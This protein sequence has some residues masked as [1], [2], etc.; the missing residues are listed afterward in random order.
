MALLGHVC[1]VLALIVCAYGIVVSIHGA[2]SGRAEFSLAGRRSV[3]ALAGLLTVGMIVL[4]IAFVGNDF[5]FNAVADTSSRTTPLLYRLAA[6]WSSQE[7]SLLL[8][9]WLLSMWS[10]LVLFLTRGRLR[11]VASYATA[12]LLGF[13]GFFVGLMVFYANPFTTTNPVPAEGV[14]LDPLLRFPTMMI[15]PPMLYSGYTLCTI[16]LAFA[17][18]A[19]IARRVDGEWIA[20][21]RRFALAAWLFLG[22]GILLGASWSF[23]EL[24]WGGYWGWDAVENASLLPW[25]TGTAFLHSLM[26][27]ERRG[28]LKVWNVSLPLATGILAIMGTFMVR[29]GILDSI[30][31][32]GGA[33]L[34]VPFL[35]LIAALLAGSIYLVVSRRSSL[36]STHHLDSLLSR[37]AIFLFNNLVLVG[38]AFVIFW[39]T[40]F[41]KISEALTGQAA[42]VGPP[43]F[44]RYTVPLA[45]ILVL[46]S[47]IGPVIAWRRATPRGVV[48]NL[49]VPIAAALLTLA[50]LILAG[51][52]Q[53]PAA[54]AMFCCAAFALGSVAQELWRG[55]RVRRGA[56]GEAPPVALLALIRRNRRRYGGY[57]VHVGMAVLF[58]GV[59][60]SSS[61]Q[62][63]SQLRS[64]SPGQSTRVGAYTIHYVRPTAALTPH[65]DPTH[66]GST[67][68]VGA[69]LRVTKDGRYVTT[70][71]P[72]EDFYESQEESQGSVGHLIG[73]QPVSNVGI[74]ASLTRDI[75]SAIAPELETP[76]LKHII[77]VGNKTI[78]FSRP[79]EGLFVID[80]LAHEYLQHPPPAQFRLEVSP[81]IMWIWLGGLIVFGGG[82]LA[83]SPSPGALRRRVAA[84]LPRA[85]RPALAGGP[86]PRDL[87]ALEL[88]REVKYR[89]LRD[90]ELDLATG[91]LS[92][93]DYEATNATLRAEAL[94]ILNQLE[95]EPAADASAPANAASGRLNGR[96]GSLPGLLQQQDGVSD[97]QDRE[98]DSPAVEVALH[99]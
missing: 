75:W 65:D 32:F 77:E 52:T 25:L 53:K 63:V 28:M 76:R 51:V 95:P 96:A 11:E 17:M 81:L 74:N 18:G 87:L 79:D 97:E 69:V 85:A 37:E 90:L 23:S 42:S 33:T 6:L 29:S 59:A 16:P 54:I 7:G 20:V 13:G 61:F 71:R 31:A 44:D 27:Q 2:R 66:T 1:L 83:L 98:E 46:L 86:A 58:V 93:E 38:L 41:P 39:G 30:H 15:H 21:V 88:A 50:A 48:R 72:S 62:H 45:L 94:E 78:P 14:G 80:F 35:L 89:E 92:R 4:E 3:Y 36:S 34:G 10:S 47:G 12:I 56:S 55:A 73:G 40:W 82:L 99:E 8:W 43:W 22:M 49:L 19:L 26:I 64:F 70:L 67:L 84:G 60:A 9:A 24:G 68:N 5:A 91:K 57:I